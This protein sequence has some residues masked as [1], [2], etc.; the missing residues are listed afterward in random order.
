MV[1]DEY[2]ELRWHSRNKGYYIEKGYVF[3]FVSD[4]LIVKISDLRESSN[5]KILA[6]CDVC[7]REKI[8]RYSVYSHNI[9]SGGYYGCSN[10]CSMNKY[11]NTNIEKYGVRY[12]T[13]L[14][15]IKDKRK[16]TC[17][18]KYGV[19]YAQS[20]KQF[21]DKRKQTNMEKYGVEHSQSL[22]QFVDKRKQT[23]IEKYGTESPQNLKIFREKKKQTCLEKYGFEYPI[24]NKKISIKGQN[25]MIERYGEIYTKYTPKYNVNS[26]IYLDMISEKLNLS[27]QHAL[28]GGEKKIVKYFVDGYIEEYNV[29][30][31]WDETFHGSKKFK[32]T[33]FKKETFLK[34]NFG[35]EII[36][37]NQK[38][39]LGDIDN[40][41]E[42]VCNKIRDKIKQKHGKNL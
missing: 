32:G 10:K 5:I 36:R 2:I 25:T 15:E 20:L 38:E 3:T 28:N 33:D 14:E 34:E 27:I 39:F 13:E 22:K 40:Q 37:I 6:K 9:K 8:L 29:C 23:N 21:V 24:Q 12:A 16:Q 19:E 18:K 30:I 1:L 42:V 11:Y 17:L 41:I 31:E 4:A 7:G 35:C 26:I